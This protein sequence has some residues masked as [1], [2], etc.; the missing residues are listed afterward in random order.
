MP[1]TRLYRLAMVLAGALC[2]NSVEAQTTTATLLGVV[3]DSS[4]AA[5][6]QASITAR[7]TLTGFTRTGLTDE[8]G[9]YLIP[10]LP[11]G[12]YAVAAE[13]PGFRRFVQGGVTLEVNQNARVDVMLTVGELSESVT[14]TAEASG[15]DTRSATIGEL[16][17]RARIQ[18]L[19]LNGRNAMALAQVV[20]GVISVSA[21]TAPTNGR[22][23]PSMTVAGGRNTQNE[24]RFDGTAHKNLTHNSGLNLPS[25]DA[26]QEFRV[27]TSSFSAE[28][29]RNAGGVVVAVTRA[30][31][32]EIHG[33]LWNYLRNTALN[34][35]NTFAT[36]KPSLKQNQFGFTFGGP[37][38]RNKTFF[39]GSY[40]GT[41]IRETQ[42][43]A[44]ATPP[45]AIERGGD[46]SASTR[47]PRDPLTNQPF[48]DSRIPVARFD[49]VASKLLERYVPVQNTSDGRR[50]DLVPRPTD[51][52]QYLWR[53]DHNFSN[54]NTFNL[55]FFRD[56]SD[57]IRQNGNVSPYGV[58][59][60]AL[61]VDNWALRD[62]H[63]FTP[64][65]LNELHLGVNRVDTRITS[66]DSTQ[67]TDLGAILPGVFPA[68]LSQVT[69]DGFFNMDPGLNYGEHG[70]VYQIGDTVSWFR[71]RHA[72]KFGGE[73]ER[74]EMINRASTATNG[75]FRFDGSVTGNAFADYLIGKPRSLD[76]GSPY[77]R[78]VKGYNWYLFVQDDWRLS[79]RL[80]L[81]VGLRYELFRPYHHVHDWTNTYRQGQKSSVLPAAPLGM[82]FP[83]DTGISRGLVS[84]DKNNFAPRVGL[85][86]DPR[87]DGNFAVRAFYGLFYEDHRSDIWTYPAVNQPFVIREFINNPFSLTDPYRGR[88]NPFPYIYTPTAAKFSFPMGL[89]TVPAPVITSPYV[90]QMSVSL[91]KKLPGE[92]VVKAAYVGKLAHNLLRMVQKNPA[93]YIPGRST[94]ANTDERRTILPGFYSRF[95]EVATNSNAAYHS[96]QLSLNRRFRGGLTFL[97]SYTLGKLLDYYSAQNIGQAPQDPFNHAADRARSDEDRR[98]VFVSSFVYELPQW[99]SQQRVLGRILGGWGISGIVRIASGLPVW[100]RSDRDNSLT[101]VGFDRPDLV[102]TPVRSH[103]SRD[104]MIREFFNISA[105]APNQPGRYGNAGRNLLSGPASSQTDLSI[106]KSFPISERLG[107]LQ[108]RSE[109]FNALNQVSFGGP[110]A[111]LANRNFGRIQGAASP[112]ILQFA[113]RYQ[114]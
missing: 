65:L 109:F 20:P 73:A 70:N 1:K 82:V 25:P 113:L 84:V 15:V 59:R 75:F 87:G 46:F 54:S 36:D 63:T 23:G 103:S 101:G 13:K 32:N 66:L 78:V 55:R 43:F 68:Q 105:F 56:L 7:N 81:N 26:L 5:V 52:D 24:F 21:P 90:H 41:R 96:M 67:F 60:E 38:K 11:V 30:G 89:F 29:G 18:E 17:D 50:V 27:L 12:R 22:S 88:V 57:V 93:V 16:V 61:K 114:F 28:Y 49:G 31:T 47:R 39:F 62:T 19:P 80:T 3:R 98:H 110:E 72:V 83:G 102:G 94:T 14:V 100:V 35:R 53:V 95:R 6:P 71:G 77:D 9:A 42:L 45:A 91:E 58:N 51:S 111:R 86:W 8:T 64:A 48:P 92:L 108:F 4:G 69:V 44:T 85:A 76:Q 79:P 99:K 107:A 33:A 74:T 34:A 2:F 112:R 104:D 97:T 106:T 37:A 10:S 40:Q